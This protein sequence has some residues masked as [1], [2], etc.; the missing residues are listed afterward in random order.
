MLGGQI[1]ISSSIQLS[2][3]QQE[4]EADENERSRF[5]GKLT[6][7]H[8]RMLKCGN[9]CA[10]VILY[11]NKILLRL[12][13]E[14]G[15]RDADVPNLQPFYLRRGFSD[16]RRAANILLAMEYPEDCYSYVNSVALRLLKKYARVGELYSFKLRDHILSSVKPRHRANIH[17]LR[18]TAQDVFGNDYYSG[19]V[20]ILLGK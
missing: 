15:V 16:I 3:A 17:A 18:V 11:L 14:N 6:K 8:V 12:D 2:I 5:L 1:Q 7:R 9:D 4:F 13:N 20:D 19:K 10:L